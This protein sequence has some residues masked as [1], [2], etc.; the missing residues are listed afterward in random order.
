MSSASTASAR[1]AARLRARETSVL[2][3]C[4]TTRRWRTKTPYRTTLYFKWTERRTGGHGTG[5][6][7]ENE[8][9]EDGYLTDASSRADVTQVPTTTTEKDSGC[10]SDN[11]GDDHTSTMALAAF[12]AGDLD[13]PRYFSSRTPGTVIRMFGGCIV[14][15]DVDG[16]PVALVTPLSP[17]YQ[18]HPRKL[19]D[20]DGFTRAWNAINELADFEKEMEY[21]DQKETMKEFLERMC[22]GKRKAELDEEQ[23][24]EEGEEYAEP[25]WI[26]SQEMHRSLLRPTR[27]YDVDDDGTRTPIAQ[28]D[29][30]DHQDVHE[31]DDVTPTTHYT[32]RTLDRGKY[33]V[34]HCDKLA[35]YEY[36]G[37][38]SYSDDDR[39]E[40]SPYGYDDKDDS[41]TEHSNYV[42]SDQDTLYGNV[43]CCGSNTS[44]IEGNTGRRGDKAGHGHEDEDLDYG[45]KEHF[46]DSEDEMMAIDKLSTHFFSTN[47]TLS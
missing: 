34:Q 24:F 27:H 4:P 13:T 28:S 31:A 45:D 36:D 11:N 16:S 32:T 35:L 42:E 29:S 10:D 2:V 37:I 15:G 5:T 40:S 46:L 21:G 19:T 3:G 38:R 26:E 43:S 44:G 12:D 23:S 41:V 20:Y 39:Y 9:G 47:E 33:N 1:P 18:V 17:H 30:R 7:A 25:R 8:S 14:D 6:E 22:T